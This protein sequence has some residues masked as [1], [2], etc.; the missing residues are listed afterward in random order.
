MLREII[1]EAKAW[2]DG[3]FDTKGASKKGEFSPKNTHDPVG[4]I[5]ALSKLDFIVKARVKHSS[6]YGS[7]CVEFVVNRSLKTADTNKLYKIQ[8]KY[9]YGMITDFG[10]DKTAEKPRPI[11][12]FA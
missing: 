9:N 2:K 10:H 11:Y 3:T 6:T 8:Q 12:W 5:K 7:D 4:A 1:Q